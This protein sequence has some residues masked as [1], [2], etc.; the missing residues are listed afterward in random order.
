MTIY[1]QAELDTLTA[2]DYTNF[3]IEGILADPEVPFYWEQLATY[4]AYAEVE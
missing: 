1:T 3:L 2:E 4:T